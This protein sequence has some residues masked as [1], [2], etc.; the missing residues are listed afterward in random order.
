MSNDTSERHRVASLRAQV[1]REPMLDAHE[2]A[3]LIRAIQESDDP[4]SL[5]RLLAAH[6]RMVVAVAARHVRRGIALDD[7]ISEGN[8]GLV[9]AARRFDETRAVRFSTFAAW[10]I[11]ARIGRF[12]MQNRRIVAAPGTRGARQLLGLP[13]SDR[14]MLSSAPREALAARMGVTVDD[15]DL[16]VAFL[17][18]RDAVVGSHEGETDLVDDALAADDQ[19]ASLEEHRRTSERVRRA[20]SE[21]DA[22]ER[23]I[24]SRRLLE[25]EPETLEWI[26]RTHGLSRERVRQLEQ[27]AR[28]KLRD[29]LLTYAASA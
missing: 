25:D 19:L 9:E 4:R 17:H 11:R 16:V 13:A 26:G 18:P 23:D 12:A 7:L 8:L 6:A 22:R 3:V 21:L 15:V 2:E 10:W 20:L 29:S 24:V 14:R 1:A 5:A 27:R 28:R